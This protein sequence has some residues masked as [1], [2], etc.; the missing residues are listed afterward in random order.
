MLYQSIIGTE[1]RLG[2]PQLER[3]KDLKP[4]ADKMLAA[5]RKALTTDVAAFNAAASKA[6]AGTITVK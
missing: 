3:Y 4:E 2:T 1:R 5:A 6:G